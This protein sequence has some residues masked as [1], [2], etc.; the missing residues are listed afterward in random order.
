MGAVALVLLM[1]CANLANLLLVRGDARAREMTVRLAIG[2]TRVRLLRQSLTESGLSRW[3]VEP[4]ASSSRPGRC[5]SCS[6]SRPSISPASACIDRLESS[7]VRDCGGACVQVIFG[8]APALRGSRVS[9]AAA[10]RGRITGDT[11]AGRRTRDLLV[12]L[13]SAVAVLLVV[14]ALL[15]VGSVGALMRV[16]A[17]FD[18][19]GDRRP[20]LDAAAERS[21]ERTLFPARP[22][23]AVLPAPARA[24]ARAPR[25]EAAGLSTT[26]PLVDR[27]ALLPMLIEG[28]PIESVDTIAAQ[29]SLVGPGYLE[30]MRIGLV[31]GRYLAESDDE[32]TAGAAM[33]NET[34]ARKFF[35]AEDPV[36]HRVRPGGRQSTAPWF[37]IVGVV[38]D[39]RSDGLD[40][41][42]P[43]QFYRRCCRRRACSSAGPSGPRGQPFARARHRA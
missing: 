43:P 1:G 41:E 36:G 39:V 23:P 20:L 17:G 26:L 29:Q 13:Q 33:V 31:S 19:T 38:R 21:G 9:L 4:P 30:T 42:A 27:R 5:T 6:P 11:P 10:G 22:A 34:F 15:I 12:M 16:D 28:R 25:R 24:R 37:T 35:G 7:R 3:P 32:R 14:G 18:R 8:L 2:A 40:R